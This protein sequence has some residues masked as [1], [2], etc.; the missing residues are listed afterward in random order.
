M[1]SDK[2]LITD[3]A[4]P[5]L[6]LER[7]LVEAA[8]AELVV[9]EAAD[10]ASL[11]GLAAD[12]SG[13]LTCWANVPAEVMAAAG[14]LRVVARMGIGL[15]NIDVSEA[16]RRKILVT[17]VPDYCFSEVAEHTLAL[18]LSLGRK[19][20]LYHQLTQQ[21]R[22]ERSVGPPLR[23]I[24]GQT[25]GIV[26]LGN[27]GKAVASRAMALG[28][29]ILATRRRQS[30]DS[31]DATVDQVEFV[32]LDELLA[33]SDYVS[34]HAPATPETDKL[35]STRELALMKPT[36]YLINTSRGALVDE[37]ALAAALQAG[38]LAGAALDVQTVEPPDLS[39]PPFNDPRVLVTPHVAFY[40][41]ESLEELRRRATESV[42]DVL[43]GRRPQ[44]VVNPEV[45]DG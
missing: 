21:G 12:V 35:I 39:Q 15:D 22:Y 45:L 10:P 36:A 7:A 13:I 40:S 16:T 30:R 34:L 18:L 9:A 4:W 29:K 2:I 37:P 43:A 28:M 42:L 20:H 1:S 33:R 41:E 19:T 26:G 27:I 25:L 14:R 5:D 8:G 17:N 24:S 23:R 32:S 38:Q 44:N 6:D 3:Y 31:G 11:A